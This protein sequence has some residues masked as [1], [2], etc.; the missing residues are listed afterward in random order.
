MTKF[1]Q[2]QKTK[3]FPK[4]LTGGQIKCLVSSWS[5]FRFLLQ[6]LY[7]SGISVEETRLR[8]EKS[9]MRYKSKHAAELKGTCGGEGRWAGE[10][11]SQDIPSWE[12]DSVCDWGQVRG[13]AR[14]RYKSLWL[15]A[16]VEKPTAPMAVG[17]INHTKRRCWSRI[18]W[19]ARV[20]E[21]EH[22]H[23][24]CPINRAILLLLNLNLNK[25]TFV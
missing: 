12:V 2:W 17:N 20:Q 18:L 3:M 22:R 1:Y 24:K 5:K 21:Y 16:S 8:W 15:P 11:S 4:K 9:E 14:S 6:P 7:D 25:L 13:V 23:H 10:E 19:T